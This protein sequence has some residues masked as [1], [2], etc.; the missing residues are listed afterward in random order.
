M[1]FFFFFFLPFLFLVLWM[2]TEAVARTRARQNHPVHH[3]LRYG[4]SGYWL[5]GPRFG[6][7]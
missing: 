7:P 5:R 2:L 3:S 4:V 6:S 1:F